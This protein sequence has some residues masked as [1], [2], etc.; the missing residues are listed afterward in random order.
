MYTFLLTLHV[1]TAVGLVGPFIVAGFTGHR[2][3]RDHDAAATRSA[4]KLMTRFAI[5]VLA[6]AALGFGTLALSKD[7]SFRTP[8]VIV[9]ITLWLIAMGIATGYTVPAIRGAANMI[10]QGVVANPAESAAEPDSP[11][12]TLA[13]TGTELAAKERLDNIAG[14][15]AGSASLVTAAL[16]I[17]VILMVT[18]PFGK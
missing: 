17:I 7:Y 10:E 4:A 3:I 9:A 8:W 18:H 11:A 12:P 2:A 16:T 1:L 6:V 13:A 14:R 5:G 15:V